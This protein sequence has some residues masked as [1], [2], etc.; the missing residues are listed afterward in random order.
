MT[1]ATYWTIITPYEKKTRAWWGGVRDRRNAKRH[2]N[3]PPRSV[4]RRAAAT[5]ANPR[6]A[7]VTPTS[8]TLLGDPG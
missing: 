2:V 8:T 3:D 7:A 6:T 1:G 5:S 4:I